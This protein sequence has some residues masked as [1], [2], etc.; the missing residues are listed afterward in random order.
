M[1]VVLFLKVS[2]VAGEPNE[3]VIL[4]FFTENKEPVVKELTDDNFES[5]TQAASGATTGNW[6]IML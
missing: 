6:F 3:E 5:L 2:M 4:H 1:S